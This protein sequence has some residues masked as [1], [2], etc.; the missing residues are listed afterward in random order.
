MKADFGPLL[1]CLVHV[2][3]MRVT[4]KHVAAAATYLG[5]S[6]DNAAKPVSTDEVAKARAQLKLPAQ[7]ASY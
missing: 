5:N 7:M 3:K 4:G 6:W 1:N 2:W